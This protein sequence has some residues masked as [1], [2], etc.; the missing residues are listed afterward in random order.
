VRLALD[1][2]RGQR[3]MGLSIIVAKDRTVFMA[4]TTVTEL[5]EPAD[6]CQIAIQ[7]AA[8]A[9]QM[10]HEPRVALLSHSNFG[11]APGGVVEK[12]RQAVMELDARVSGGRQLDF[13]YDGELNARA[14][15]SPDLMKLYPFCRLSGPANVLIM[16]GLHSAL[17][18]SQ[19]LQDLGGGTVIGPLLV[20]LEKP[21]QVVQ[22]GASVSEI[23]NIAALA[24]Y[25]AR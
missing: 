5:P 25:S 16:P 12:V 10:G 6:L 8:V 20:G 2:A 3:V 15:L 9:R 14:A 7:A 13:E 23:V 1:A 21:V 24:A 19:L 4:D 18:S 11:N 17:L 22:M